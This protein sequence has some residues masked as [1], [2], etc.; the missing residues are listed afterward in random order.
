M[1]LKSTN[2]WNG[3]SYVV[4]V[5]VASRRLIGIVTACATRPPGAPRAEIHCIYYLEAET[6]TSD[7][8]FRRAGACS[9]TLDPHAT[10]KQPA[11]PDPAPPLPVPIV[12]VP[13]A[14]LPG[15]VVSGSG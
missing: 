3:R 8:H 1:P 14:I 7:L 10:G 9:T 11:N 12:P 4:S 13:P 5:G 2:T 15:I 6:Y